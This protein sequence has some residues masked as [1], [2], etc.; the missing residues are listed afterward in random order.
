VLQPVEKV[1]SAV[2]QLLCDLVADPGQPA[3]TR[4]VATTFVRRDSC[5]CPSAG[6]P[7]SEEHSRNLFGQVTLLQNTLNIQYELSIEL[8]GKH[9]SDPRTLGWLGL[10]PAV[11]GALGL[12]TAA[13]EP[14]L[15]VVGEFQAGCPTGIVLPA[16]DFPPTELYARTDGP[17]GDIVFLVPVRSPNRDWGVL[18]AVSR[19]QAT[20]PPGREMM[21]HSGALL[22]AALDYEVMMASLREKEEG[23]RNAALHD[24]LTG[25]PNR[26]LLEDRMEQAGLR[27]SRQPDYR[28]AILLIDLDGFKA[29][30]DTHGHAAGDLL[31]IEVARRLTKLLRK[32]D[33]VARLGGDEFVILLDGLATANAYEA[34]CDNI[35]A[36]VAK[37]FSI[38]GSRLS[39][40]LSIGVAVSGL[41]SSD[42]D[43]LLREADAEMYRAKSASRQR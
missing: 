32:S 16:A 5:G 40:G 3:Q 22:A 35:R 2:Y 8:L 31:L 37:P 42:P 12:W 33:T 21:N 9:E 43:H 19:I 13:E 38:D 6:L 17:A 24:H 34:V 30:N 10:T 28:F 20:T 26:V 15:Q 4:Y 18:A 36:A 25:L 41:G 7:V 14:R 27:A 23:L 39:V 11:A 1:G 29:V